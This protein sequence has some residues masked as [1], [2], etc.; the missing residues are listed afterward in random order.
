MN[1]LDKDQFDEV[2]FRQE[3]ANFVLSKL[4]SKTRVKME[5]GIYLEKNDFV[6]WQKTLHRRGWFATTW[7]CEYGGKGWSIRKEHAFLQEC[8]LNAAPWI[9]PYGVSMVGPVIY[10]FGNEN[11]KKKF[12]PGIL[13]SD[14]WWCQGY[15]EPNAG[16]DL[17][18]LTTTA[19][20]DGD[21]YVVNG[22]KMW[23]TE[24]HWADM[25][26]CLVRTDK[27]VKKQLGISFLLIDMSTPGI[28]IEPI[29]TLDGEHHTN[30]VFLDDVRVPVENLVGSE[31]DGWKIAK[32]LLARER[33]SIADTGQRM[34]MM[35][36]IKETFKKFS[37]ESSLNEQTIEKH[38][39]LR[40]EASLSALI[41]LE[42]H[43]LEEW[44]NGKDDGVGA[45]ALKV[46]S[47]ELLQH[48]TEFWRDIL[49]V[50][51]ACY[52]PLLRKVDGIGSKHPWGLA[53]AVNYAYLYGRC[54]TIFGGSSE[55]QRNIIATTLLRG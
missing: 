27:T 3:V 23:T 33:A 14:T 2:E 53:A 52:D 31:G 17:A 12:L 29:V 46:R 6:N 32:F 19:V 30:Q 55:I 51:G 36:Q 41:A 37:I 48:M 47:T 5:N 7:P 4:D 39:L 15:S 28:S 40:L 25:M 22:T 20:R 38:K 11:Q 9:I 35:R 43:Y 45:S 1:N 54:W 50:Y 44:S 34:R 24:A 26:H 21:F 13:N 49:G 42:R 18:S 10:T 8:A 16:S